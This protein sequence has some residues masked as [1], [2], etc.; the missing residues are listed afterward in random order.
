MPRSV[1]ERAQRESFKA[2][3]VT[4]AAPVH[5]SFIRLG[6][7]GSELEGG[8]V[9]LAYEVAMRGGKITLARAEFEECVKNFAN[10]PCCPI[11]IEHADVEGGPAAWAEP[12][13]HIE[14]LRVGEMTRT[15]DGQE[16]TVATLEGRPSYLGT[17]AAD[18]AAG[19]WRFGSIFILKGVVDEETDAKLGS[20]LWSWSLTA[21]PRLR[22]VGRLAPLAAS[23]RPEGEGVEA[24]WWYGSIES[25]QDLISCLREILDLPVTTTEAEVLL[26]LDKLEALTAPRADSSGIDVDRIVS[27]LRDAL[28]LPALTT[29]SGV[30]AEVRKGLANLPD[31]ADD[32]TAASLSRRPPA[33]PPPAPKAPPESAMFKFLPFLATFG[34]TLPNEDEAQTRAAAFA[35]L[36]HDAL[37]AVGLPATATPQEFS[38]KLSQLA[39]DAARVK[40]LETELATFRSQAAEQVKTERE[41]YFSELFAVQPELRAAEGSLRLHA[42]RDFEGFS[43]AYPRPSAEQLLASA[44]HDGRTQVLAGQGPTAPATFAQ[45]AGGEGVSSVLVSL[46]HSHIAF[47]AGQGRELSFAD[48]LAELTG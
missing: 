29:T 5:G 2:Q 37:K 35:Q 20:M 13:G 9:V 47:A 19:K 38:A 22:D 8:W 36:G 46:V 18:V 10:Y 4:A 33:A 12:N 44:G 1:F 23:R 26:E 24:S 14:E 42:E 11:T 43:K 45:P 3:R 15:V 28:R 25:R 27:Q 32:D 21:H 48:A 34:L 39:T 16:R 40:G 6:A 41:K 31:D 17:T 7:K 30:L